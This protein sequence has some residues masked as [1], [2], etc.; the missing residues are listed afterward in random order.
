[1]PHSTKTR[2]PT[3]AYKF[4]NNPPHVNHTI[5]CPTHMLKTII[6]RDKKHFNLLKAAEEFP[7]MING[8]RHQRKSVG[9]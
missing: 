2:Y 6:E 4:E 8:L 3:S 1:M 9:L 7:R 5:G